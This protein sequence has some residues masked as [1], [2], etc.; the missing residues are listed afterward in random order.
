MCTQENIYETQN[1]KFQFKREDLQ[2]AISRY[3]EDQSDTMKDIFD[4][5]VRRKGNG[6]FDH[7]RIILRALVNSDNND[8]VTKEDIINIIR[9]EEPKYPINNLNMYLSELM[10]DDRGAML[11]Y[12]ASSGRYQF[13]NPFH[14]AFALASF[15]QEREDKQKKSRPFLGMTEKV[16]DEIFEKMLLKAITEIMKG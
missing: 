7:C 4:R 1:N 15:Q 10:S 2:K 14:K 8:G 13:N 11:R 5:A 3:L 16:R 6:R 9:K 12:D